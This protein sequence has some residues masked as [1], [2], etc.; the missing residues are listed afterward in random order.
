MFRKSLAFAFCVALSV[1]VPV[2]AKQAMS[3]TYIVDSEDGD[4]DYL[5]LASEFFR[6]DKLLRTEHVVRELDSIEEIRHD[7]EERSRQGLYWSTINIV[8]HGSPVT[9]LS[10]IVEAGGGKKINEQLLQRIISRKALAPTVLPGVQAQTKLNFYS[11]GLGNHE[12]LPEM[13][14]FALLGTDLA[15]V[16]APNKYFVF[17]KQSRR[18][19]DGTITMREFDYKVEFTNPEFK[20]ASKERPKL[21]L[22]REY[23]R[24]S[25]S[26]LNRGGRYDYGLLP[27][28]FYSTRDFSF[29][30]ETFVD[31]A[32]RPRD[33]QD[34]LASSQELQRYLKKIGARVRDFSWE[35]AGYTSDGKFK[36]RGTT[37]IYTAFTETH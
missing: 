14:S 3:I 23:V 30:F 25:R 21:T 28:R 35:A 34:V 15:E 24:M 5:N 2:C 8:A 18:H 11:C 16:N 10:L 37:R 29:T 36:A 33:I 13:L 26:R 20:D 22:E 32:V 17:E 1:S 19:G 7:L 12:K 27:E 9:G 31:L 6:Y 4:K